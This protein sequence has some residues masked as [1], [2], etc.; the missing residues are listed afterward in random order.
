MKKTR[1]FVRTLLTVLITTAMMTLSIH[2]APAFDAPVNETNAMAL[3][4]EYDPDGY[5]IVQTLK[6]LGESSFSIWIQGRSS[7]AE[8][9]DTAVHEE[10][11]GYTHS[12]NNPM[13]YTDGGWQERETIYLG[14]KNDIIVP[15]LFANNTVYKTENFTKTIPESMRT[16]RYDDYVSAGSELS[17][18]QDG[19]YG[20]LNEYNAYSWGFNNSMTLYPYYKANSTY[21]DYYNSCINNYQAYEEFR[22]WT[23]GLLNYE[24][25]NA[26]A[27][28][29]IHMNNVD[30]ANAYCWTTVRFRTMIEEFKKNAAVMSDS[31]STWYS[32]ARQLEGEM[33]DRGINMLEQASASAE[34]KAIEEELFAT[35]TIIVN[36]TEEQIQ[37]MTEFVTRLYS[38]CLNRE[39][40]EGGL[41]YW[42][43]R[44]KSRQKTAAEV[45][46]GFF[47]SQEMK[48]LGLS[49]DEYIE[50]CYKVMMNRASDASGKKY[51]QE[52]LTNGMTRMF[53]VRGFVES[54]EF[55]AIA[56]KYGI[57]RGSLTLSDVRDQNY[58]ITSF[59]ARC[60]TKALGRSFD[61]NG[62][63][64]WVA[65]ILNAASRKKAA[66][67]TAGSGFLHSR[68][69]LNKNLSNAEYVKV[70]YRLFLNRE[71]DEAGLADWTGRLDSGVSRDTVMDG[72]ANSQEFA[73]IMESYGIR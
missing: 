12:K 10:C 65:K 13:V 57:K 73:K 8:A 34:L 29:K 68:E 71:Y 1:R 27:Q 33:E 19:I 53:V 17:A 23:L 62:L 6:Q 49:D 63:K 20:L 51:W 45:V 72:F 28:Y 15:Y 61:E 59:V 21:R 3:L 25:K 44:L 36:V 18:N 31:S 67:E 14:D 58:G 69:F 55:T 24:K 46:Y 50:R 54:K 26:P 35:A 56:S 30:Y 42:V 22:Y 5:Y 60:Y 38:L 2:A 39:P 4:K 66:V 37:L 43:N 48:N 11:H 40:D 64:T 70:L 41:K 16:F 32:Y 9:L 7:N 52:R 47:F